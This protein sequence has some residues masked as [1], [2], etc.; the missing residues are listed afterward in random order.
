MTPR[1][2]V[3]D[4]DPGQDDALM[5]ML[6]LASPEL[7]ILGITAVAGNVPLALTQRNARLICELAGRPEA[8]V[9]AG[10]ER[11]MVREL[12]TAEYVHGRSG[13]DGIDIHEPALTLQQEHAVAFIVDALDAAAAGSI[14]LVAT[15]PLTNLATAFVERPAIVGKVAEIVLMGGGFREGGNTTPAAEFNI[16][17]DPDAAHIVFEC[18]RPITVMS[19]D[20]THQA[21]T[22]PARLRRIAAIGTPV[23]AAAHAMLEF[24][25]RHDIEKYGSD[26]GPLHDPCTIA[27]L[28]RPELFAGKPVHV[29][30]ETRSELTMGATV[31]D[32]WGVTGKAPNATWIHSL[33]A[34]GFY[35]LLIERL[36]RL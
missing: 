9:H 25:D 20:V 26:G 16:Y 8:R 11:P 23:A 27:F 2:V 24:Y 36:A 22:T 29:A 12:V 7:D 17:V 6:A 5:L 21:M 1:P 32:Y 34:D 13:I 31:V 4:C 35:D 33:D 10:C 19:L 14:T 28:L 18:G 15:G 3:I 30:I